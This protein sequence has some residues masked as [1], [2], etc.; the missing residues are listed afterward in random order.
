MVEKNSTGYNTYYTDNVHNSQ[1]G[2]AMVMDAVLR[3]TASMHDSTSILCITTQFLNSQPN[4]LCMKWFAFTHTLHFQSFCLGV[5]PLFLQ[6][7]NIT[8]DIILKSQIIPNSLRLS[9]AQN[10][11]TV[12]NCGQY[13]HAFI[14]SCFP[15]SSTGS[16]HVILGLAHFISI[17][18]PQVVLSPV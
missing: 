7:N 5:Y 4:T 18:M 12:Q 8:L 16:P 10:S 11:P 13:Q 1:V 17:G 2:K 3:F 9:L 6:F 14:L 15:S